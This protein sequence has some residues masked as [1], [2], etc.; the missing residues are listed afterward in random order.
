MAAF[1]QMGELIRSG[2]EDAEASCDACWPLA[3][4]RRSFLSLLRV[5]HAEGQPPAAKGW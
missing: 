5:T 3:T 2:D 4:H 1:E